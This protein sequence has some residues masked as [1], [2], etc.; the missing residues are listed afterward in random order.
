VQ[1]DASEQPSPAAPPVPDVI[2]PVVVF[3]PVV[4]ID[5][6]VVPDP[7][8][9]VALPPVPAPPVPPPPEV[10]LVVPPPH[11]TTVNIETT[12]APNAQDFMLMPPTTRDVRSWSPPV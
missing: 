11:A 6:V 5:P 10:L 9:A 8:V 1:S 4:V 2:D 7:V 12:I 3:E